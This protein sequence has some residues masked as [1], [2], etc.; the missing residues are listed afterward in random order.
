MCVYQATALSEGW[1]NALAFFLCLPFLYSGN[2]QP[3]QLEQV[4]RRGAL[5]ML[6]R[7]GASTYYIGAEGGTGPEYELASQ[8][9]DYL[10]VG[11]DVETAP[12][13]HEL[14]KRLHNRRG[15]LIAA[16]LTRTPDRELQFN[17]GP[18]YLETSTVALYRRGQPKPR[19]MEDLVGRKLMVLAG[20]SYEEQL[21]AAQSELPDLEWEPRSDVGIEDLLLAISDGAI[22]TTLVD[23]NIYSLNRSFYPS[24]AVGFTLEETL[25][26]AW[27]FPPGDDDSLVQKARVFLRQAKRS[28][29]LQALHEAFYAP[30]ERLDRVGM[31]Q[32]MEQVRERLPPLLP[33]FQ[34]TAAAHDLDWRLL[35]AIGYQES[36]WDP[37]ASS[38]T[39]VRGIMML[40]RRTAQHLGIGDR[41]D[42]KQSIEGGAR[43]FLDLRNRLPGRIPEPD[44]T[45][46]ALTAYNMG[47]GHL[48]DA[49]VLTQKQGGDPDSWDDVRSRLELLSQKKY[50][51]ETRYG[52]ARGLEARQYVHNI[53]RYYEILVWMDT[54]E[55][56]LLIA[57]EAP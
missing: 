27:A 44:R 48:E 6:T 39:G 55:H 14:A 53:R 47:M 43:Y 52:Y 51:S 16:N 28:G 33:L 13:F 1:K 3:T 18:D 36:H 29:Q 21:R 46:M 12:A 56:P 57:G 11:I 8:F 22:D 10:G 41:R 42:A 38:Y 23:S 24:V 26:H 54:R 15:D 49:R 45:W 30:R 17:F 19:S 2:D 7:N 37:D 25:S 4:L 31:F 34:E 50:H 35:A 5:I 40:T 9:A 20:T 32:F